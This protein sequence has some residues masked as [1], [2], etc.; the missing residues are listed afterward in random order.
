MNFRTLAV[1]VFAL[2]LATQVGCGQKAANTSK[3]L[4]NVGI[5]NGEPVAPSE[6][7]AASTVAFYI[8][9]PGG[10]KVENFCTGTVV[11]DVK[12]L[13]AA[14]CFVDAAKEFGMSLEE[15]MGFIWVGFGTKIVKDFK[16][17]SVTFVKVASVD[18]HPDYTTEPEKFEGALN[19]VANPDAAVVTLKEE[20][21]A[22]TSVVPLLE[23]PTSLTS[24][25]ELTLAG[26]GLTSAPPLTV[27]ATELNKTSVT[28]DNP[29]VNPV[30]FLYMTTDGQT[31]C[32]GDSGGPA[33]YRD[34]SSGQVFVAGIT[35]W[36]DGECAQFGIYSSVPALADWIKGLL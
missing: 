24:G 31:A 9:I 33:Y 5:I 6:D 1:S 35:S 32:F 34:S 10:N 23:G 16:D 22:G 12:I 19:G 36:G 13:S 7:I 29:A 14:H 21:P 2:A 27:A 4:V 20:I 8:L 3:D 30:Q 15:F 28:V 26:F 25:T 18:V 11:G 17:S